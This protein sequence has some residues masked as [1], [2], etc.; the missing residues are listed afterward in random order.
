MD[1]GTPLALGALGVSDVRGGIAWR[2]SFE[3]ILAWPFCPL[4]LGSPLELDGSSISSLGDDGG[5][6]AGD[7]I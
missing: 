1:G 3:T 5:L 7:D 2:K 4:V 6:S